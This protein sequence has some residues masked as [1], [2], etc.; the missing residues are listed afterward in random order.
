MKRDHKK[1]AKRCRHEAAQAS[2]AEVAR[3]FRQIAE[4]LERLV[5][6]VDQSPHSKP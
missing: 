3:N 4:D 5:Q 6:E 1:L 2:D